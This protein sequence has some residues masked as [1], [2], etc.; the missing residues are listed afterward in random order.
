MILSDNFYLGMSLK[1]TDEAV[2]GE[3]EFGN[4]CVPDVF[5]QRADL[6]CFRDVVRRTTEAHKPSRALTN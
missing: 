5:D 3:A 2:G 6:V 1:L 4:P